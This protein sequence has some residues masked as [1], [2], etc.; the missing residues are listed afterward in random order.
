MGYIAALD[1]LSDRE[2]DR[3]MLLYMTDY[4]PDAAKPDKTELKY[5]YMRSNGYSAEQFVQTY[6]VTK[7]FTK[8]ADMINAWVALGYSNEE[9]QMFYKLYKGKLV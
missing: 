1:G 2:R 6:G 5:A 9:A 8:K 4:N 3:V 7:E